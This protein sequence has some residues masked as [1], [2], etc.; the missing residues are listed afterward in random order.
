M[1]NEAGAGVSAAVPRAGDDKAKERAIAHFEDKE[2]RGDFFKFFREL[3]N[4]YEIISPD[5]FLRP[6]MDDYLCP[7]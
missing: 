6:F 1:M 3:E 4:L 7:G 2:R 5:A